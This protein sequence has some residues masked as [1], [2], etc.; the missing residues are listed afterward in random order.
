MIDVGLTPCSLTFTPT[1]MTLST[2]VLFLHN[3][4]RLSSSVTL[5]SLPFSVRFSSHPPSIPFSL[6][7]LS[8]FSP[9]ISIHSHTTTL[10]CPSWFISNSIHLRCQDDVDVKFQV[11]GPGA[12]GGGIRCFA[13]LYHGR[14]FWFWLGRRRSLGGPTLCSLGVRELE[15]ALVLLMVENGGGKNRGGAPRDFVVFKA[16][17]IAQ[18]RP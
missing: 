1:C 3:T 11:F 12:Q 15:E 17:V 8:L 13:S 5:P 16:L 9:P 14:R 10:S 18:P 6:P 4:P 7:F 2:V